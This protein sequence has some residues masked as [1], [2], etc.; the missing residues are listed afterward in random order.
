V[1]AK[2]QSVTVESGG[3]PR[4]ADGAPYRAAPA[5]DANT[6]EEVRRSLVLNHCKWD[7]QVG[8]TSTL[9]GFPL[10]MPGEAWRGLAR[11]AEALARETI[12]A[13]SELLTRPDLH[14]TLGL[15]R[16]I[17]GVLR[18]AAATGPT[19]AIARVMR[20][21]FHWTDDGWRISEVNSD[22]PGGY[23]EGSALPA[24]MAA[25]YPGTHPAGD[26]GRDWAEAMSRNIPTGGRV[27]M[28]AA[29]G[30]VEDQQV[31]AY[32]GKLLAERGL[33]PVWGGPEALDFSGSAAT[34]HNGQSRLELN[35]IVRFFQAEW[36]NATRVAPLFVGGR[37]PV[38]NPGSAIL[39]ESKRF[40]LVWNDLKTP[41]P[42][43]RRLLP[44]TRDP[45]EAPW[46]TDDAWL[47]K[48]ALCNNGDTVTVR[49]LQT[50]REWT[51]AEWEAR[52]QPKDWI[53]QRRFRSLPIESPA[54]PVY[55]CIGVYVIDGRAAGIY[56]RFS[57]R[58]LIDFRAVD[59]A[60]LI[61]D[62]ADTET[63][64]KK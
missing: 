41:T 36:L 3:R 33:E 26:P 30:Y 22:V 24:L 63:S 11:I 7:P 59:V 57:P 55:P 38:C 43:W 8:D 32:L 60:V 52:L 9:A 62:D 21:D 2:E 31:V 13:E 39:T 45:R 16:R 64:E 56:A 49:E 10:V 25:H 46:R 54:G 15:P 4:P 44:E 48:T 20:F 42:T 23:S 34:F 12:A 29:A 18:K 40:P 47:L 28:M 51:R 61:D 5:L 35:A 37:T 58:A 19:P 14:Y 1:G 17:R 53:A 27:M 50:A 6:Y